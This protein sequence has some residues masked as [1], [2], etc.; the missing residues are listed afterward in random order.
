MKRYDYHRDCEAMGA[1]FEVVLRGED[2][3]HLD[4]VAVAVCEEFVRL[5]AALSRFNPGS[6]ISR[7]NRE[8]ARG[9]VRVD[10]EVFAL[11]ERC[12][13]ARQLTAGYFDIAAASGGA[14]LA[15]YA[16]RC[17][18]QFTRP[19]I[20]IDLGAIGKGYA[21]N[22]GREIM[23]RFG[24]DCGW[25]QGGTSSVLAIGDDDWIVDVRHPMMPDA[26]AV[27]RVALRNRGFSCSAARHPGQAQSDVVN[28]LLQEPLDGNTACIVLAADAVEAEVFSTALLSMGRAS[29]ACYLVEVIR[30]NL[31]VGWFDSDFNWLN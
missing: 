1:R 21:L 7:V 12:E 9:P 13:A 27:A 15:L 26:D 20:R 11:L 16:D 14:G 25:L 19:G 3:E 4:A 28:P 24:V 23:A 5:D 30:P 22:C 17:A 6:E 10:R 2:A 18:V 8:A 31:Q 29:A